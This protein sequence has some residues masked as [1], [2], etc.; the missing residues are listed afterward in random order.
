MNLYNFPQNT[1]RIYMARSYVQARPW[2]SDEYFKISPLWLEL[3]N[4]KICHVHISLM[5]KISL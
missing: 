1:K 3:K 4:G 2:C 5:K